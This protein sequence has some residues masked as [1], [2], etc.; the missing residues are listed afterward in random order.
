MTRTETMQ[1]IPESLNDKLKETP[2]WNGN[3]LKKDYLVDIMHNLIMKYNLF[4]NKSFELSSTILREKYGTHY[5]YYIEWLKQNGYIEK[6]SDYYVGKKARTYGF[7]EKMLYENMK[8]FINKNK[9][10]MKKYNRSIKRELNE[11]NGLIDI[12]TK[13]KLIENLFR[14]D[15]DKSIANVYTNDILS[16]RKRIFNEYL[17]DKID[18]KEIFY[19]FDNYGR[20]HSNFTNLKSEI[21]K[22]SLRI[23]G[24]PTREIDISNSQPL[25]LYNLYNQEN[26]ETIS[27][28]VVSKF[29]KLLREEK[30]YEYIAIKG[31][32]H[33]RND[34]KDLTYK[35]LFGHNNTS[36]PDRVFRQSFPEWHRWIK[37]WKDRHGSHQSLSH[38][39]QMMESDFI[40]NKVVKDILS[41][42]ENLVFF[43]V[44]DSITCSE[45]D[46]NVINDIFNE[47]LL[48]ILPK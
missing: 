31:D 25:F 46:Y 47:H 34:A 23:N 1:F 11:T 26:D 9:V 24:E 41:Y 15:I 14:I 28:N 36:R 35:V 48:D 13:R 6:L 12:K 8:R 43:T 44:H 2:E 4:D 40:F 10:L 21:R 33:S 42:D 45:S 19:S 5:N 27:K 18:I 17:V 29:G 38:K 20:L 39:L 16:R 30:F 22:S 37:A 7:S 3:V 32:L